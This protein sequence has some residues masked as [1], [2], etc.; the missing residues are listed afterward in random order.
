MTMLAKQPSLL[1]AHPSF[2]ARDFKQLLARAK[3]NPGKIAYGTPGI[4]TSMHMSAELIRQMSGMD[5]T[6][7]PYKSGDGALTEVVGGH[8]PLAVI[9]FAVA[10]PQVQQG[11][12]RALGVTSAKR[13]P[14]LPD[15]PTLAEQ[16]LQGLEVTSWHALFVRAGTPPAIVER[17]SRSFVPLLTRA[18]NR[19]FF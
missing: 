18:D 4:G 19:K 14:S 12:L 8:V 17:L 5:I 7:V 9:G 13:S 3:R 10:A 15:V 2:P 16:G 1:V 11:K 6:H